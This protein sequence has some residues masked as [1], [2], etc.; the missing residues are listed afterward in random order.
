[1]QDHAPSN[2]SWARAAAGNRLS[3]APTVSCVEVAGSV[4][5]CTGPG[6]PGGVSDEQGNAAIVGQFAYG[7]DQRVGAG[8]VE[9]IGDFDMSRVE[10]LAQLYQV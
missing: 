8:V 3:I 5:T 10:L 1:M 2:S 4:I 7:V 6:A 9:T